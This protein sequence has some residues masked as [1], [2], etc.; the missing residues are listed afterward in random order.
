VHLAEF[1]ALDKSVE[2]LHVAPK[3]VIVGYEQF[4]FRTLR[5]G[6]QAFDSPAR[7]GEGTLAHHVRAGP[8]RTQDVRLVQ[9]IGGRQHDRL[10]GFGFEQILDVT[11]GIGYAEPLGQRSRVA[12]IIVTEG[13]Q[14]RAAHPGEHRQMRR[15]RNRAEADECH[16][17]GRP[18]CPAGRAW[19]HRGP[20][21]VPG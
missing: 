19:S 2:G 6:K 15:L 11:V 4:S 3:P 7:Q 21:V 1:S 17:H 16:A 9:V 10:D 12:R 14:L 18:C 5:R 8:Q 20:T 13:D